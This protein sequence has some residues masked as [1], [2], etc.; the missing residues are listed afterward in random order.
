LKQYPKALEFYQQAL[1]IRTEVGDRAG[2]GDNP[3]QYCRSLPQP[4]TVPK[5]LEF[6]QQSLAIVREIGNRENEGTSLSNIGYLLDQQESTRISD[7]FLQAIRQCQRGNSQRFTGTAKR[8]TAV[9][10]EN[11]CSY[12]SPV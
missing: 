10:H 8:A 4:E 2:E 11:R 5:A 9:L 6:Y 1:A 7:C 12:L 3:Q